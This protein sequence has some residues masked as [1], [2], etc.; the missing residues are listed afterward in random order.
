MN[1]AVKAGEGRRLQLVH[2][3]ISSGYHTYAISDDELLELATAIIQ[4]DSA[5]VSRISKA[6][7]WLFL[8][9]RITQASRPASLVMSYS[10]L[11]EDVD[12]TI[13]GALVVYSKQWK[14]K[15]II[16]S[17]V[18]RPTSSSEITTTPP[19]MYT[20]CVSSVHPARRPRC[21]TVRNRQH[22]S[23]RRR[24]Q[25]FQAH[26]WWLIGMPSIHKTFLGLTCSPASS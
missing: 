6:S 18:G 3:R 25:W 21:R 4:R 24:A 12:R 7:C 11:G 17:W 9:A 2:D 8:Q 22:Q 20:S 13:D 5:L 19:S 16:I 26:A 14:A 1:E 15:S 23:S 10:Q